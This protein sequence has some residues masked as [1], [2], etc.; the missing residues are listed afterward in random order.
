MFRVLKF[1]LVA[2]CLICAFVLGSQ[3]PQLTQVNYIIASSTL[4]LAVIISLCF[5][6]GVA[7][8]C[9]LSFKMFSQLKWQ[10]YQLKKQL[11]PENNKKLSANKEI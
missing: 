6:V 11:T 5:L 4:P 9:L 10:N 8:G 1:I 7:I 3:N 2:I